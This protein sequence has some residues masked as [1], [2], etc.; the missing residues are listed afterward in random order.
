MESNTNNISSAWLHGLDQR[1]CRSEQGRR[2][3]VES[4]GGTILRA[5]LAKKF[6]DPHILASGGTKYCLD[7]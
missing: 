6:F 7:S 5:E 3:S 2:H 1:Q 4:G